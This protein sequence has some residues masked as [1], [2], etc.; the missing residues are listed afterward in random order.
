[1][2]QLLTADQ[3]EMHHQPGILCRKSIGAREGAVPRLPRWAHSAFGLLSHLHP[4]CA[5]LSSGPALHPQQR[6]ELASVC[7]REETQ[8][9][10]SQGLGQKHHPEI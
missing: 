10:K 8:Q 6:L 1:M 9:S 3:T 4:L 7:W 2:L 5:K